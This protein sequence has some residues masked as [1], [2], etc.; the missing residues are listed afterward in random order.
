M[1]SSPTCICIIRPIQPHKRSEVLL[2][3]SL[4]NSLRPFLQ[5]LTLIRRSPPGRSRG[6]ESVEHAARFEQGQMLGN[7]DLRHHYAF[8][9]QGRH[10][11][12]GSEALQGF[13]QRRPP[14]VDLLA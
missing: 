10:E 7:L 8:A 3:S 6:N 1:P 11:A 9:R 14:D 2:R 4:L 12:I 13:A 5:S